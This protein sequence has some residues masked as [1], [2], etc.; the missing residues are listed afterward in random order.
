MKR[1]A[2]IA[3]GGL[4]LFAA[5]AGTAYPGI[6]AAAAQRLPQRPALVRRKTLVCIFQRGAMDGIS[7]VQPLNDPNLA[8]ARP[9]LL[10]SAT[11]ATKAGEQ[12]L[13]LNDRFGLHASL[14]PLLPL[15]NDGRLAVVHG[16]GSPLNNRSHF[17]MQDY[18]EN[19]TPGIKSTPSGW[20]NR[21]SGRL[22]GQGSPFRSVSLTT[23]RP[24][25]FFGEAPALAVD[26]L[27]NL[28]FG[29]NERVLAE[30]RRQYQEEGGAAGAGEGLLEAGTE[31]LEALRLL[32]SKQITQ[33]PTS[34]AYP[35]SDL[36]ESLRQTAQLIKAEVGL[37]IAF[38]ESNGWDSHSYQL[39]PY[40]GFTRLAGD[41][42]GSIAT[43]WND[44]GPYR[45]DVLVMTMTEF[46]RTIAENGSRGTDHGRGSCQFLLGNN[47][48]GGRVY[49][50]VPELRPANLADGRDL[51][52]TTDFRAVFGAVAERHLG[53][54][55]V[56]GIFPGYGGGV[57]G[58]LVN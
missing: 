52:V 33:I 19:G 44:L 28:R 29:G 14:A 50:T 42:G 21:L 38:V 9:G 40:G 10:L 35:A 15:Y 25:S 53:V 5:A 43:F 7:A 58:G 36:G 57:M 54:R 34:S 41:L 16:V 51:P 24:R 45:D 20:L 1:R 32:K 26:R 31:G 49:G 27:D 55:D 18:L 46:G 39:G 17:D 6:L 13:P 3:N 47:I 56:A 23:A 11:G 12:L 30:L 37:E 2:F 48:R 4:A 8:T 22:S